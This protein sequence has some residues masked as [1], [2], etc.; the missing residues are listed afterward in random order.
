[1]F[2][3]IF[4]EQILIPTAFQVGRIAWARISEEDKKKILRGNTKRL[5]PKTFE[6]S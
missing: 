5:F 4:S 6:N 3:K 1:M 2:Y